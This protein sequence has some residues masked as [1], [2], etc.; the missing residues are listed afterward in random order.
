ME[1]EYCKIVRVPGDESPFGVPRLRG[2]D[3]LKAELR[4]QSRLPRFSM[5]NFFGEFYLVW[6]EEVE[7]F[8]RN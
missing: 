4:T 1:S 5:R 3:R 7:W 8:T 6:R 2:P